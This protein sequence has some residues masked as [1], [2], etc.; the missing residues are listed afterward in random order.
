MGVGRNLLFQSRWRPPTF[1]YC[2]R[3]FRKSPAGFPQLSPQDFRTPA[4]IFPPPFHRSLHSIP[5]CRPPSPTPTWRSTCAHHV[6]REKESATEYSRSVHSAP[7]RFACSAWS[8]ALT[9]SLENVCHVTTRG[10]SFTRP[11][12]RLNP[13]QYTMAPNTVMM[14]ISQSTLR[15]PCSWIPA[16]CNMDIS[17]IHTSLCQF[18]HTFSVCWEILTISNSAQTDTLKAYTHG[19]PSSPGSESTEYT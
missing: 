6:G 16:S 19:C 1:L 4:A 8:T 14:T 10:R 7:S 11:Q 12:L 9:S 3:T 5:P 13:I 18:L 17:T 15:P 2:G